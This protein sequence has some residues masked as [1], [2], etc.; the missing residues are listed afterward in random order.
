MLRTR[1]R[2]DRLPVLVLLA[3]LLPAATLGCGSEPSEA[4]SGFEGPAASSRSTDPRAVLAR[5]AIETG[6]PAAAASLVQGLG[7]SLGAEAGCLLARIAWLEGDLVEARR[8]VEAVREEFPGDPRS[9]ATGAEIYA[10]LGQAAASQREID[11]G[12]ELCGRGPELVRALGVLAVSTP[13]QAA[14]GLQLLEEAR[15]G[16]PELP[17]CEVPLS[18]GYLMV[19]REHLGRAEDDAAEAD[20]Q[21][22]LELVPGDPDAREALA[23]VRLSQHRFEEARALYEELL[24]EGFAVREPLLEATRLTA[25][26]AM[27]AGDRGEQVACYVRMRELGVAMDD[28]GF[29][30]TVLRQEADTLTQRAAE[31]FDLADRLRTDAGAEAGVR[32]EMAHLR[33]RELELAE[34]LLISAI[35]F[36]PTSPE[37]HHRLGETYFALGSYDRA[38]REWQAVSDLAPR[39]GQKI[40]V[41]LNIARAWHQF[42]DASRARSACEAYLT[43]SPSGEWVEETEELLSRL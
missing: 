26:E 10:A 43:E 42:G 33:V 36:D 24:A 13:G 6:R 16:D 9:F 3:G 12:L 32:E 19:A 27:L 30:Q 23:E 41:H 1:R 29:G 35:G 14:L 37:A 20:V 17:F 15:R 18:R 38:A 11:R 28:L 2:L 40:G 31:A 7:D 34:E 5:S 4:P 22:S 21:R 39:E 8:Q 25:T